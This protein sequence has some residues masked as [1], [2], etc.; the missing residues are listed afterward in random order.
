MKNN[1][2]KNQDLNRATEL[3][4]WYAIGK[5]SPDDLN[6]MNEALVSYPELKKQ[7]DV[8]KAAIQLVKNTPDIL[9]YSALKTPQDRLDNVLQQLMPQD[10]NVEQA[11][12]PSPNRI[13]QFISKLFPTSEQFGGYSYAGFAVVLLSSVFALNYTFNNVDTKQEGV[14]Y[15]ASKQAATELKNKSD[16][17]V[18]LLGVN[19]K[20]DSPQLLKLLQKVNAKISAVLDKAGMYRLTLDKKLSSITI[21]T[22]LDELRAEK[23]LIWFAGESN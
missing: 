4:P 17:T 14:F 19:G 22:L 3:L 6:F 23:E 12:V 8:E 21:N 10:N 20:L 9:S 13:K 16:A 15:P 5:L 2:N 7:L 11:H 18:L 1:T